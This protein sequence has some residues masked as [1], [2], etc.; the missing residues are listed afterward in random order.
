MDRFTGILTIALI[1]FSAS[2][3]AQEEFFYKCDDGTKAHQYLDENGKAVMDFH[4]VKTTYRGINAANELS[5][6][7]DGYSLSM[8]PLTET[9][10]NMD[11]LGQKTHYATN[12]DEIQE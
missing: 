5:F 9:R 4:G 7:A 8:K 6:V 2:S 10:F 11:L 1:T 3:L 12:C